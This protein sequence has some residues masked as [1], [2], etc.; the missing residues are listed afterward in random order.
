MAKRNAPHHLDTPSESQWGVT[1]MR[2]SVTPLADSS[3]APPQAAWS[4]KQVIPRQPTPAQPPSTQLS[5]G[6]SSAG[7][8]EVTNW[9]SDTRTNSSASVIP[10]SD[11]QAFVISATVS[12]PASLRADLQCDPG[13]VKRLRKDKKTATAADQFLKDIGYIAASQGNSSSDIS[14]ADGLWPKDCVD[15]LSGADP[16]FDSLKL[17]EFISGYIAITEATLPPGLDLTDLRRYFDYLRSL[18]VDC[19]EVS[20]VTTRTAH[21]Q[22]LLG[23][24]HRRLKWLKQRGCLDA[25]R[26]DIQHILRIPIQSASQQL[27][28]PEPEINLCPLYQSENS[29]TD[30]TTDGTTYTHCCSYCHRTSRKKDIHPEASCNKKSEAEAKRQK[31]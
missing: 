21:K 12:Q 23:I 22:V 18:M 20:W 24:H 9:V 5:Q 6:S 8:K 10:P 1:S 7:Q 26:D 3:R 2:P 4:L 14:P 31:T 17:S 16:T 29:V 25:K 11:S 28:S 27:P 30:H 15:R 13:P 19:A